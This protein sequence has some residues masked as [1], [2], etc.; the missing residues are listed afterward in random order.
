M[1][2]V[3]G[4][5]VGFFVFLS[6]LARELNSFFPTNEEAQ[7]GILVGKL[8]NQADKENPNEPFIP[9]YRSV[10]SLLK[11]KGVIGGW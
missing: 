4:F 7:A 1:E 5:F 10:V 8:N 6:R 9:Y 2:V 3:G 11:R